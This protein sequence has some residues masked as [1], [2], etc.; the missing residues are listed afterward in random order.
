MPDNP[1]LVPGERITLSTLINELVRFKL[2]ELT[3]MKEG[4]IRAIDQEGYW[5][6]GG[7]LAEYLRQTSP[8]ADAT[9][10]VQFIKFKRIHWMQKV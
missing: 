3:D 9:S 10:K 1:D 2:H 5:I 4:V 6:E 8:G 7:S